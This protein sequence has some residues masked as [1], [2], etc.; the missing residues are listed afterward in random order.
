M[1]P[2]VEN[3]PVLHSPGEDFLIEVVIGAR[4]AWCM[5]AALAGTQSAEKSVL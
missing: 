2:K 1:K 4:R 3:E 5:E